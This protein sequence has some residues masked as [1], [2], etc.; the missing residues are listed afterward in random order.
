M[1][2]PSGQINISR[3][4][5]LHFMVQA[6][7]MGVF[8]HRNNLSLT[9]R[10]VSHIHSGQ[11]LLSSVYKVSTCLLWKLWHVTL[12]G[13]LVIL[14]TN[15]ICK[16][17]IICSYLRYIKL[18]FQSFFPQIQKTDFSDLCRFSF[19]IVCVCLCVCG[20][21]NRKTLLSGLTL[22]FSIYLIKLL[23]AYLSDEKDNNKP[24]WVFSQ[25]NQ[26]A[27]CLII[28]ASTHVVL[29]K[30]FCSVG[31]SG[32]FLMSSQSLSVEYKNRTKFMV[33]QIQQLHTV[34]V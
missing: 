29:L 1:C 19:L 20:P 23:F 16:S 10:C 4:L 26:S 8:L 11:T 25:F 28:T 34:C 12:T 31:Y 9:V 22:C 7:E 5:L 13:L 27:Q 30:S 14:Q 24:Y 32:I 21:T 17:S 18:H 33:S 3:S 15:T 2:L 6:G